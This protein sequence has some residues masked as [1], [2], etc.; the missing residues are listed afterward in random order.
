MKRATVIL[1]TVIL[2]LSILLPKERPVV[3]NDEARLMHDGR[4]YAPS[5]VKQNNMVPARED[6]IYSDDFEGE[7]I[8]WTYDAGWELTESDYNSPSHC[9][10]SPN[11]AG[12]QNAS[13]N[14]L[15]PIISLPQVGPDD[16]INF[17]FH[18][19]TNQVDSDGDGDNFLEDYYSVSMMDPGE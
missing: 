15:S 18:L 4:E 16:I 8:E 5:R 1:M 19:Y 11:D 2:S 9:F 10:N 17:G 6:I 14:L 3:I 12:T 13:W 7:E